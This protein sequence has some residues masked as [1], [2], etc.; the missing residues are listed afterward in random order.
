MRY[1]DNGDSNEVCNLRTANAAMTAWPRTRDADRDLKPMSDGYAK[2]KHA[3]RVFAASR[4]VNAFVT[5][6]V[7]E[8]IV[9]SETEGDPK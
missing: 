5:R 1:R 3:H 7:R 4:C 8:R 6:G 9:L 2:E